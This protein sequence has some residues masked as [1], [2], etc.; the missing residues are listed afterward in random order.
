[1]KQ[2]LKTTTAK[3]IDGRTFNVRL[4]RQG[5]SYGRGGCITHEKPEPMIEFYDP[6]YQ[7]DEFLGNL[8]MFTGGRYYLSTLTKS[9]PLTGPLALAGGSPDWTVTGDS[10]NK[11]IFA[12]VGSLS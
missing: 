1:M 4:V 8:G 2:V 3:G 12:L 7:S 6:K 9:G 5:E 11:A 10:V